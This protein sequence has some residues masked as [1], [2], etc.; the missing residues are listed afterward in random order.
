MPQETQRVD[1]WTSYDWEQEYCVLVLQ[2]CRHPTVD[3]IGC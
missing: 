1:V 3:T 2:V